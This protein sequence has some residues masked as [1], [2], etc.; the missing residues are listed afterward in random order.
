LGSSSKPDWSTSCKSTLPP[1]LL[2]DGVR[3]FDRIDPKHIELEN[4]RVIDSPRV[5]HLEYRPGRQN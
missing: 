2:G 5:T 1:V 4:T 3:L